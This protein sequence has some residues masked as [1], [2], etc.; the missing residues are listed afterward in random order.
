MPVAD[1]AFASVFRQLSAGDQEAA[2][3]IYQRFV[4]ELVALAG[5]RLDRRLGAKVDPESAVQSAMKSALADIGRFELAG[6]DDVYALLAHITVRKCLNR[7]RDQRRKKRLP[8]RPDGGPAA[9]VT[10]GD[11]EPLRRQP[12]P[13]EEAE[14]AEL[15]DKAVG[16][17][18]PDELA[19]VTGVLAGEP[20]AAVA[21]RAGLST[22]TVQRVVERF[23]GR[24][25]GLLRDG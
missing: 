5:R 25:E 4:H 24:L 8:H 15:L 22:R 17:L 13:D 21:A 16:E 6:W 12:T 18:A 7:N 23:R 11:W 20:T 14:L 3:L 19:A 10:L 9:E 2:R 1:P